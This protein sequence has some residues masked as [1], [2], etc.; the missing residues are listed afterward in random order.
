MNTRGVWSGSNLSD[1]R[2]TLDVKAE[3]ADGNEGDP[4]RHSWIV[5]KIKNSKKCIMSDVHANPISV[6]F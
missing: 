6:D 4:K 3:D 5:G 1:G 2:H